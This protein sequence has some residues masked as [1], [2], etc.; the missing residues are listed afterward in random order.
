MGPY[1]EHKY[2]GA[3]SMSGDERAQFLAWYEKQKENIFH[4]NELL[5]YC[6][7]DVNVLRQA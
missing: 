4:N 6:M 1:P 7:D 5:A 3:D 2:Y